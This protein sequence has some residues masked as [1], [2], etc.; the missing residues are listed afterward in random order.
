MILRGCYAIVSV[1][2][3][4]YRKGMEEMKKI[5][6]AIAFVAIAMIT[7]SMVSYAVNRSSIEAE[8]AAQENQARVSCTVSGC[9]QTEEHRHG[10]CGINGCM[11]TGDHSHDRCNIADCTE[12]APHMHDG[13]YCYPHTA[14]DGHGYHSCGLPGCTDMSSHTHS[15]C[16][17]SGCTQ[18]GEHS[19]GGHGHHQSG[20]RRGHH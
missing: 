17:V 5:L 14:D 4:I 1:R 8:G 3:K 13:V 18:A 16:G 20:H 11:L 10:L 7:G 15:S 6:S 2:R 12:T 19:H 9:T